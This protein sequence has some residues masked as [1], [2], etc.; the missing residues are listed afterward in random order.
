[1][2]IEN[3]ILKIAN[4]A[5]L[6]INLDN[7]T[8]SVN[9]KLRLKSKSLWGLILLCCGGFFLILIP[10]IKPTDNTSK[11]LCII[12][13]A[14]LLI[15]SVLTIIRQAVDYVKIAEGKIIFRYNLKLSSI[16]IN[17]NLKVIMKK[18]IDTINSSTRVGSGSTFI[19][20]THCIKTPDNKEISILNFQMD[21]SDSEKAIR[22]GNKITQIINDKFNDYG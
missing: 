12:L 5:N 14:P 11:I 1:M 18:K 20:V 10:F 16:T 9:Q 7:K 19:D 17:K 13:G 3:D 8:F 22:L 6:K 21:N 4:Q 15:L 2:E